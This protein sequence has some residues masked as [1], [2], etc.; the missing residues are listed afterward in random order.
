MAFRIS[1]GVKGGVATGVARGAAAFA[2]W[3]GCLCGYGDT[4]A[5]VLWFATNERQEV[6]F[7]S[8]FFFGASAPNRRQ[9]GS[10][11]VWLA[12]KL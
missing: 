11:G 2:A 7:Q 3:A 6:Q 10:S 1:V 8:Q 9:S 5:A 4:A 12:L